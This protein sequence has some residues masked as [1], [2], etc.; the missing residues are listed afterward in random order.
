MNIE[1][2]KFIMGI[3]TGIGFMYLYSLIRL[4]IYEIKLKEKK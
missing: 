3:I 1:N 2:L 4:E